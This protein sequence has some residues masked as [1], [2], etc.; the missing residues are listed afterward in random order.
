MRLQDKVA[1]ITGASRGIGEA[2]AQ[3]YVREGAKVVI[4]SRKQDVLD[5][6]S[7][8]LRELGGDVRAFATHTG[9]PEQCKR[10]IDY[11][12]GEFGRVDILINNAATNPH[13]AP[14]LQSEPSHWQKIFE[15]N[16]FGYFWLCKFAAEAMQKTGGGKII[17]MASILGMQ[18]GF[19][20][21]IYST[22]KAAVVMLTKAL[23]QELGSDNIQVNAIAPGIIQTKF[24]QALWDNPAI[25]Q[26]LE[27]N[28]PAGRIG[29]PEDIIEAAIYLG[30]NGSNYMTGQVLVIDGGTSI[31]TM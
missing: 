31:T 2:I 3:G 9:D 4:A 6:V 11:T 7:S 12:V 16:V 17:N 23:A 13:F 30:S 1:I 21:G 29:Q 5:E 26:R 14:M 22:S 27:E 20:M 24:A 19:M 18:P 28:T 15:V 10:L 25:L 8:G